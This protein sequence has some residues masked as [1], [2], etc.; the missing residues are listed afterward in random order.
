[1][2][3]ALPSICPKCGRPSKP[4]STFCF[5]CGHRLTEVGPGAEPAR[6]P[7]PGSAPVLASVAKPPAPLLAVDAA[8]VAAARASLSTSGTIDVTAPTLVVTKTP[9]A[10]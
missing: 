1:M 7:E 2:S 5:S 3:A 8:G 4:G 9:P 10:P 6:L